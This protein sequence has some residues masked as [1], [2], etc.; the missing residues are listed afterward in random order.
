MCQSC[1]RRVFLKGGGLAV[2]SLA[3][4]S[5]GGG[6]LFLHRAALAASPPAAHGRR[7][8]LVAVFQRGAMDGLMAVPPLDDAA[9][10]R[11]RPRLAMSA[12]RSAAIGERL[13]ELADGCGL[14]PALA[15]L[16]PLFAE[17]RCAVVHGVGSPAATRS[18]FDAQDYME[19]GTPGRKGTPSGWLNRVA[20]ELGHEAG[21]ATAT[22]SP[23]RAVA[24]AAAMPRALQGPAPALAVA[25]LAS[26]GVRGPA[27]VATGAGETGLTF[28]SLYAESTEPLLRDAGRDAF[29][30][31][32]LLRRAGPADYRPAPGVRYPRSPLGSALQQVAF[33]IKADL[34]L[35]VAFT[36]S[37]GWDTHVQQGNA[38]GSFARRA[39]D[40]ASA[41]TAF[42]SD[43][44]QRQ[45]DVVLLT[46][47]EFGRTVRENGS[48]GTDHGHGSCLFLLGNRVDGGRV[49]GGPPR[50][51]EGALYDGRDLPVGTDFRSV[52]AEVAAAHLGVADDAVLFPGWGGARVPLFRA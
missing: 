33:L 2:V 29:A 40:L 44:G 23:F 13:L 42:W 46:M 26:F 51:D 18:H 1:S 19:S 8:V 36:E 45:D 11:L 37:G 4:G 12:A 48:G 41:I 6:P 39:A 49:H 15:P 7:K 43:L 35:E 14:H 28:E 34:G 47:T 38:S 24:L 20:G 9:L 25:D 50:L 21:G 3:V 10:R 27:A 22:G 17:G 30:A 5:L 52:F 32:E 31:V 16:L